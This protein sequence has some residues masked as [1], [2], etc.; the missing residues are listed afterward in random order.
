M[1]KIE[2]EQFRRYAL[3]TVEDYCHITKVLSGIS[4]ENDRNFYYI[5]QKFSLLDIAG[6][7]KVI[8]VCTVNIHYKLLL[9]MMI[10]FNVLLNLLLDT[11]LF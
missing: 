1:D 5:K 8:K 2:K 11:W 3:P 7:K 4:Q 9:M 6:T 10:R